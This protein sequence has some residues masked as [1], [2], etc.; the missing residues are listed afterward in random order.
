M[1]LFKRKNGR[2]AEK[3]HKNGRGDGAGPGIGSGAGLGPDGKV[4]RPSDK[5][6]FMNERQREY[7][8]LKLLDWREDTLQKAR[9]TPPHLPGG[10]PKHTPLAHPAPSFN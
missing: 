10:S 7:F 4:Y 2:A 9:R 3:P 8:R 6:P 5:E 1:Q